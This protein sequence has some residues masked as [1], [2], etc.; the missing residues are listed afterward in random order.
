MREEG[1]ERDSGRAFLDIAKPGSFDPSRSD[2]WAVIEVR[3]EGHFFGALR[4]FDV[5]IDGQRVGG[6]VRKRPGQF[7]VTPGFHTVA[8]RMDWVRTDSVSIYARPG[9]YVV[10]GCGMAGFHSWVWTLAMIM[11][12]AVA[13]R[14]RDSGAGQMALP[15][16]QSVRVADH[17][18]LF[19]AL[20]HR[21]CGL[22]AHRFQ[23]HAAVKSARSSIPFDSARDQSI[24]ASARLSEG[25][26]RYEPAIY[27][28]DYRRSVRISARS[29]E[30][31][32]ANS[33]AV[34]S[35]MVIP[36]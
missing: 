20:F 18:R 21:S 17:R 31:R 12:G 36:R 25:P 1:D 9:E 5:S 15:G 34:R 13:R 22:R 11:L 32:P 3:H 28:G 27:A 33:F 19:P 10:L 30:S 2:G 8:A 29:W 4:E 14:R 26:R 23:P 6:A 16:G 7:R 24:D 35:R